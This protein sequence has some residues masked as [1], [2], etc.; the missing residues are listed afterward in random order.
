[1]GRFDALTQIEE[2]PQK[3]ASVPAVRSPVPE[4]VKTQTV[5]KEVE[6]EKKPANLQTGK[7]AQHSPL[8]DLLEKPEKYSTRLEPSLVKKVRLH[9]AEMDMNDYDVVRT[10]LL[11]YFE[12]NT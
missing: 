6:R 9:A 4:R 12:R 1:M 2:T 10:A 5:K 7:Q 3:K 8:T 11:E